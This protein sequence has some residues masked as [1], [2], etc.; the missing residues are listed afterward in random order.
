MDDDDGMND[1]HGR[2]VVESNEAGRTGDR[3]NTHVE[4]AYHVGHPDTH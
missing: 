4:H 2:R 1:A 3:Q